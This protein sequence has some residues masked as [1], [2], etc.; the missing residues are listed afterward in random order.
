[1]FPGKEKI[2][3]YLLFTFA[4]LLLISSC[5]DVQSDM[6][7]NT[8]NQTVMLQKTLLKVDSI[9]VEL[10][11]STEVFGSVEGVVTGPDGN[12]AVL[13]KAAC[14]IRIFSPEGEFL[15]QISRQ[16]NG[17]GE[18]ISNAFLTITE[19]GSLVLTGEGSETLGIHTFNYYTGE[20]LGSESSFGTPP[21]CLEG[22]SG[23]TYMR[24]YLDLDNSTGSPM[25]L[26]KIT[27]NEIGI[28]DPLVVF[29]EDRIPFNRENRTEIVSLIWFGYDLA[30]DFSG[31]YYI[32]PRSTE[33][34]I[35]YAYDETGL[36]LFTIE[37]DLEPVERNAEE[38]ETE[39]LILVAKAIAMDDADIIH[40][41]DPNPYKPMIRGLEVNEDGNLWVLLG[42]PAQPAFQVFDSSGKFLYSVV[43]EGEQIDGHSWNFNFSN[44]K[45][46]AYAEDPAEGFQKVWT[47]EME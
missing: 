43:L 4:M 10:G 42:G 24:K 29:M 30:C 16:G 35:I 11:D 37:L 33:E 17:P 8:A 21:T 13:D 31:R 32:A 5:G 47:L 3:R 36:E 27:L 23:N 26:I 12:I 38:L 25:I 39:K 7:V 34:A 45:I 6:A 1:M 44:G 18:L 20:W 41:L 28:E 14:C 9:G 22:S 46:L 15:R 2:I 40:M 19:D